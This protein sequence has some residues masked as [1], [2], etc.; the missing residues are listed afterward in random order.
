MSAS[1]RSCIGISIIINVH[2]GMPVRISIHMSVIIR[3]CV[4]IGSGDANH[5]NMYSIRVVS[6][7]VF[8]LWYMFLLY[9]DS[10][11]IT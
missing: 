10:M 8:V 6:T 1:V 11:G 7:F 2:M 3:I 4:S 9:Q 5:I